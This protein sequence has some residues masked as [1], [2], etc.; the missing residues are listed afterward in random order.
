VGGSGRR[1]ERPIRRPRQTTFWI[2]LPS[3]RPAAVPVTISSRGRTPTTGSPDRRRTGCVKP[4]ACF[5]FTAL[6]RGRDS[7]GCRGAA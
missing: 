2:T 6:C 1:V 5:G 7:Q 3:C 4:H